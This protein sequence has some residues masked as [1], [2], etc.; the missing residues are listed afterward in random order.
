M[1]ISIIN[2]HNYK[3]SKNII[4]SSSYVPIIIIN[5]NYLLYID[6]MYLITNYMFMK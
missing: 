4:L 5:I 6:K 3:V 2:I 1:K